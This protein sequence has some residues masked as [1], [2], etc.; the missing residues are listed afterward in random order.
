VTSGLG[1]SCAF[2]G[3]VDGDGVEDIALGAPYDSYVGHDHGAFWIA[4]LDKSGKPRKW[5]E[6]REGSEG[7]PY[8]MATFGHLG[9][10]MCGLGDI[11]GDGVPDLAVGASGW[12]EPSSSRG[13]VW[14]LTLTRDA[15][16][17]RAIEI[18]SDPKCAAAGVR[19][20]SGFGVAIANLGDLD[21][22]AYPELA[23]GQDPT[24]DGDKHGHMVF[25]VSLGPKGAVRW[26]RTLHDAK[27]GFTERYSWL[28][29]ELAGVGDI[30]GDGV[31]DV[32]I[33]NTY[34]DDGGEQRGAVWIVFL[35]RDG[36]IK[37]KQKI[38]AWRGCFEGKLRDKSGFGD[39]LCAP[40]DIDGDGVP[41]LLVGSDEGM[42][43][44]F[45]A[46][47][48]SVR[49]SSLTAVASEDA[50]SVSIGRAI[51]ARRMRAANEPIGLA[52]GGASAV[53]P[54]SWELGVWLPRLDANGVMR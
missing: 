38:S 16:I 4:L 46:H 5:M 32:A 34:D 7:F 53:R 31:P 6:L 23:I 15:R 30:D 40:G 8:R 18:G 19:G 54:D 14:I 33:A 42:W 45:L 39:L 21:G 29:R 44:L 36:T 25:I 43:T 50:S 51:A 48:G 35:K 41:D 49:S 37:S 27:D 11:D 2:L 28:G 47:D 26:V 52:I 10:S 17:A 22:D 13:G 20:E 9:E 1:S 3:D 24:I 12:S